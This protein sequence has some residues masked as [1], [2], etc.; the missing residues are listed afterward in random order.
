MLGVWANQCKGIIKDRNGQ[1][2]ADAMLSPIDIGLN[3]VSFKPHDSI[4]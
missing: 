3:R 2:K 1:F 4:L